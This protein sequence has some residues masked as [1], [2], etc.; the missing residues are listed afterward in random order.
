MRISDW[1]SDVCS[2]D[3]HPNRW[4]RRNRLASLAGDIA[5]QFTRDT[6][7]GVGGKVTSLC[8]P[9]VVANL[10]SCDGNPTSCCHPAD[11]IIAHTD[12][13]FRH[14][15]RY[16]AGCTRNAVHAQTTTTCDPSSFCPRSENTRRSEARRVGK[17]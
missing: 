9:N 6:C 17:G 15:R 10:S 7:V 12:L 16:R 5:V 8:D 1:S 14:H 13:V 2:S 4:W 3:L 11:Y